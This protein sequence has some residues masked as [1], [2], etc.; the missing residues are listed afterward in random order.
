MQTAELLVPETLDRVE[1]HA[2][3]HQVSPL[4]LPT[5][6][7]IH[8]LDN[9]R[10]LA[11]MLG[12]FLHA[13]IA[14]AN[15][16][17][18][19]WLAT[20]RVSSVVIDMA[21]WFIH[22]FRMQLFFLIS[23]YFAKFL[24]ERKGIKGF[25]W[26]RTVRLVFPFL[27]FYPLLVAAMAGCII[28]GLTYV[29]EPSGLLGVISEASKN[30]GDKADPPPL[31]TMH[32]WFVYYLVF[33]SLIAA[34]MPRL[35]WSRRVRFS[36]R[37]WLIALAP[38]V[39]VPGA[40]AAGI[41]MAAPESFIPQCWP[42]VY[43]GLFYLCGW[44]LFGRETSID[45]MGKYWIPL[46]IA[47][48]ALFVPFYAMMPVLD[49]RKLV[50]LNTIRL[51]L[52]AVI[53]SYLSVILVLLSLLMGRQLLNWHSSFLR[54]ISDSSYW[55]YLIHLPIALLIQMLLIEAPLNVWLKL[56]ITTSGTF[57]A[58]SLTYLIFVRYTPIGW[59][60]NGRRPF[61]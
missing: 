15:P 16:A 34:V 54:L 17:Q 1:R 50:P 21:I 56:C 38:L 4:A 60:L 51:M 2:D 26:N 53:E 10:A 27:L 36:N 20:D 40:T 55:I 7:R 8:Y 30:S 42:F 14:Y 52:E 23:G 39:L 22:L 25:L 32:L 59:L 31:T 11:M 9:L 29:K 45:V 48:I 18:S 5:S 12:V 13:G 57:V 61:P 6:S 24:I 3:S 28:F 47:A 41:P 49:I 19:I 46:S 35:K 43:Y 33:F 37:P 44:W 58:C